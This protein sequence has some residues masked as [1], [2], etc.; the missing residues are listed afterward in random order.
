MPEAAVRGFLVQLAAG[1]EFLHQQN[2]IH[3][4]IKSQN[5]LL[6]EC[7]IDAQLK[8]ADFGFAKHLEGANLANSICGTPLVCISIF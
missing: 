3:R 7:S 1:L 8:I 2:I 6:S 5:I 4:D